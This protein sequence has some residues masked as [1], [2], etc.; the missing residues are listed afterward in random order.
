MN[1]PSPA[2]NRLR[3]NKDAD[4]R[5]YGG[6]LWIYSNEV[7]VKQTPLKTFSAGE[8]V[9]VE[10]AKGNALG[11]AMMNP[12]TLICARLV[13]RDLSPLDE[14][15][16]TRKI[17]TALLLR[18]RFFEKPFYRLVYGESDLLPG[19]VID[20][21]GDYFSVQ[22]NTAGMDLLQQTIVD[23]LNQ[24]FKPK[25]ILFKN[26][27][28]ARDMEGL[29]KTV[30]VASGSIPELVELEENNTRFLVSLTTGQKTGWFYDHRNNRR[31]MQALVKDKN[32]LDVFS[33]VGGWGVQALQAGAKSA[34]CIDSSEPA[35]QLAR[36]NAELNQGKSRFA[37]LPG[38][39]AD[40][41]KSL[42]ADKKVFDIV[43]LDPP[44]FVK[45]IKDKGKGVEAYHQHN[46]LAL[47]LLKPGGVLISASCSMHL[48]RED[49]M[50]VVRVAGNKVHRDLQVFYQGGQGPDH[51]VH[52][53][54]A[55]TEYL[56]AFFVRSA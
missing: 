45:K 1:L 12:Q 41:L 6:H 11:V 36:Q 24:L 30:F 10:D 35:L 7:A 51:P 42:V 19:L 5:L 31:E 2:L 8:Q 34:T 22:T 26:D 16:L 15:S 53:A 49:M 18:E 40:I 28:S 39:A 9:L 20:R 43:V 37:S 55:E 48:K 4:R 17:R 54:I 52:P 50:N 3:L 27:S 44:A 21:F 38:V 23:V 25:G 13:S 32:V 33:Y 47:R 56:K 46:Q 29:E 14:T